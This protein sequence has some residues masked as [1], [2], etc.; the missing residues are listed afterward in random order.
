MKQTPASGAM[1]GAKGD[2][3]GKDFL[4]ECKSTK[5]ESFTVTLDWLLKISKEAHS[6]ALDPALTLTF[7]DS[8]G[9]AVRG[10]KWVMISESKFSEI[11]DEICK[12]DN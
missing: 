6:K 4:V 10:G 5:A 3:V 8:E 12:K 2:L 9:N 11:A 7:T 1:V